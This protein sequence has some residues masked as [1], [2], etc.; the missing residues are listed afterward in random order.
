MA[1]TEKP[2]KNLDKTV[3]ELT[4]HYMELH[5]E[6]DTFRGRLL[7]DEELAAANKLIDEIQKT[8][9]ELHQIAFWV[10]HRYEWAVNI[11][12]SHKHFLDDLEAAI[13]KEHGQS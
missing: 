12:N 10:A 11:A 3:T 9:A 4:D 7:K 2:V 13:G 5:R 6:F 8:Y 1:L